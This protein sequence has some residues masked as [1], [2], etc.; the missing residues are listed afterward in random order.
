M[1][2][3]ALFESESKRRLVYFRENEVN[4]WFPI[5]PPPT[6][7]SLCDTRVKYRGLDAYRAGFQTIYEL[8]PG[9]SVHGNGTC[10][11][12]DAPHYSDDGFITPTPMD[13]GLSHTGCGR[14]R[15]SIVQTRRAMYVF[16]QT[17]IECEI[18]SMGYFQELGSSK[19]FSLAFKVLAFVFQLYTM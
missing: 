18:C 13:T 16:H 6:P 15:G 4:C 9:R 7:A 14:F 5:V 12:C 19:R 3:K 8:M 1:I 2:E 17:Q 10:S 11:Y